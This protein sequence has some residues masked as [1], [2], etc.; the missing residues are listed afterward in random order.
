MEWNETRSTTPWIAICRRSRDLFG[1]F[2]L[3]SNCGLFFNM[4][5][6]QTNKTNSVA[7][8]PRANY[9]DWA[10]ATCRRN[11]VSTFVDKL[12]DNAGN[13]E[14]AIRRNKCHSWS[15]DWYLANTTRN[16]CTF[17][18]IHTPSFGTL[19]SMPKIWSKSCINCQRTSEP[20]RLYCQ[21]A[22]VKM[23]TEPGPVA[24]GSSHKPG[25]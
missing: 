6:K 10:T 19:H 5:L 18:L 24:K 23:G 21:I 3:Y 15:R 7:L 12:A 1:L 25:E 9:T 2:I 8:S 11:L 20:N 22:I 16:N 13:N 4:D 17:A 14:K